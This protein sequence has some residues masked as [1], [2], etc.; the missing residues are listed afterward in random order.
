MTTDLNT[1]LAQKKELDICADN[2]REARGRLI[3]HK[4]TLDGCW[5]AAEIRMI[6]DAIDKINRRLNKAADELND[7]GSDMVSA[8]QQIL[9]EE[10][11]AR[12]R[13]EAEAR[14][15]AQEAARARAQEEARAEAEAKAKAQAEAAAKAKAETEARVRAEAAAKNTADTIAKAIWGWLRK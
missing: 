4:N 7:I 5:A 9:E 2:L 15:R 1:V 12:E 14:A 3:R 10:R 6:D 11:I 8:C 13:A